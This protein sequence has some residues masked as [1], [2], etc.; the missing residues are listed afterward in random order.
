MFKGPYSV[1]NACGY[2]MC[3]K[4]G[5]YLIVAQYKNSS[6][7]S[8]ISLP[9]PHCFLRALKKGLCGVL[10]FLFTTFMCLLERLYC[11]FNNVIIMNLCIA[12]TKHK[13]P[14]HTSSMDLPL[15]TFATCI[16][17]YCTY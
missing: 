7:L 13:Y 5:P 9:S 4:E 6:V 11:I 10:G 12:K 14:V 15:N 3:S 2:N 1:S 8:V 17:N 16:A